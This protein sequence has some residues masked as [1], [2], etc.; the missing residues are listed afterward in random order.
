MAFTVA[1]LGALPNA[2][3]ESEIGTGITWFRLGA[4]RPMPLAVSIDSMKGRVLIC[5][6]TGSERT[7]RYDVVFYSSGEYQ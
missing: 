3:R 7:H 1:H 5:P 6:P 2:E 4:K